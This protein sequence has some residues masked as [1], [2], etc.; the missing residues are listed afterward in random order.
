MVDTTTAKLEW[1]SNLYLLGELEHD[2][3]WKLML[4]D[5]Y[6]SLKGLLMLCLIQV[7]VIYKA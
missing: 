4:L 7:V 1:K 2:P 5:G 3:K 6:R